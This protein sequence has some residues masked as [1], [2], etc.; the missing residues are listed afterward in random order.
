MIA[1]MSEN[2]PESKITLKLVLISVFKQE[3]MDS[4]RDS[5]VSSKNVPLRTFKSK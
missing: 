4:N 1:D 3:Y 5:S 2:A